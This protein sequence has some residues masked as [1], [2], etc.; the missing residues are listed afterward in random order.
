MV[1]DGVAVYAVR[2]R[3]RSLRRRAK[4][5]VWDIR[6]FAKEKI[7]TVCVNLFRH[8]ALLRLRRDVVVLASNVNLRQQ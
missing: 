2:T 5:Q 8:V 6:P 7:P 1:T 4:F 3:S